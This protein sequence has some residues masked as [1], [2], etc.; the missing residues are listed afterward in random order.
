MACPGSKNGERCGGAW[1]MSVYEAE[2]KSKSEDSAPVGGK[3]L[4]CFRDHQVDRALTLALQR[5][6]K[7]TYEVSVGVKPTVF[8]ETLRK[9]LWGLT[10]GND[11]RKQKL[12]KL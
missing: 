1:A 10:E 2:G 12:A 11:C 7:M 4:G 9:N 3:Y 5:D 8:S 6:E